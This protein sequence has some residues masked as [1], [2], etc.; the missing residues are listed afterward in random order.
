MA[1][2]IV[3]PSERVFEKMRRFAGI[4]G[5]GVAWYG[6]G[7]QVAHMGRIRG[8]GGPAGRLGIYYIGCDFG[9]T[10]FF[11]KFFKKVIDKPRRRRYDSITVARGIAHSRRQMPGVH[12]WP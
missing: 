3:Y 1:Y 6:I 11:S 2:G 7:Y 4:D 5:G 8:Q 10:K 12:F 9:H